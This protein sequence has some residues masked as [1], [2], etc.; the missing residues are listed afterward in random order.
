M[1]PPP[2]GQTNHAPPRA[3]AAAGGGAAGRGAASPARRLRGR[4]SSR[5]Q[6]AARHGGRRGLP[7]AIGC[8]APGP[9]LERA[10]EGKRP[11]RGRPMS[12]RG[13]CAGWPGGAVGGREAATLGRDG[14]GGAR[15]VGRTARRGAEGE[16]AAAPGPAAPSAAREGAA[17]RLA[18]G[19]R[20]PP[21]TGAPWVGRFQ[22]E[23]CQ[24]RRGVGVLRL[25]D[26]SWG[27]PG[28]VESPEV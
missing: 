19:G 5:G 27:G 15:R 4:L 13:R 24:W 9:R 18:E 17:V 25:L 7:T 16:A 20:G 26:P 8:G 22:A 2:R 10:A 21:G 11:M 1:A 23:S 28:A 3:A 6:S 12:V 14:S